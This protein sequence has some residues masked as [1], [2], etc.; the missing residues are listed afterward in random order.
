[1]R[2][3]DNVVGSI[4]VYIYRLR[5]FGYIPLSLSHK[6]N[7]QSIS[8][9]TFPSIS[10]QVITHPLRSY[11]RKALISSRPYQNTLSNLFFKEPSHQNVHHQHSHLFP[12]RSRPRS[13]STIRQA[14]P[15]TVSASTSKPPLVWTPIQPT[16]LSPSPSTF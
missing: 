7:Y 11:Q 1:M 3:Q 10:Y 14:K 12:R 9:S 16:S 4:I 6:Y 5:F 15:T 13:H 2:C 8:P